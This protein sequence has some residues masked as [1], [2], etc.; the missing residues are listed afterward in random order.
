MKKHKIFDN[1]SEILNKRSAF[2][3]VLYSFV[4][5]IFLIYALSLMYPFLWLLQS[6]L[7]EGIEYEL[8]RM[9][10]R[11]FSF[12]DNWL[13]GNF[14]LAFSKMNY[15]NTS[16][17]GMLFNSIWFTLT[18]GGVN[19]FVSSITGYCLSKFRFKGRE[20]IYAL[21]IFSM[22]IPIIGNLGASF[23]LISELNLYD[24]PIFAPISG[25]GGFG[26]NFLIMYG[27]FS[28]VSWNYA[29]AVFVDGGGQFT[30]FFRIMLP[31]AR[32]P[33]L[34]LMVLASIGNWNDYLTPI[35]YLPNYPTV[36]SGLYYIESDLTRGFMPI[37]FSAL[38]IAIIPVV[39]L[40]TILS[41]TIMNNFT[42][43]GLKG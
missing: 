16:F 26:F 28:N 12:P 37:Y 18:R 35:L 33:M 30:S 5:V 20:I 2:E 17:I 11:A 43:G 23:K 1:N 9:T 32:A 25:L 39:I 42:M 3:K 19:V 27:F 34:T 31:Q 14:I 15:R 40:F 24:T 6:A 7:K 13:F 41:D 36:A 8:D 22:T 29:E 4:F 10:Q 21:A 38:I